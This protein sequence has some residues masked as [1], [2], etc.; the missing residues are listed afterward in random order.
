V[1]RE[2]SPLEPAASRAEDAV[3]KLDGRAAVA[4][5]VPDVTPGVGF[6]A[7]TTSQPR[8]TQR[9][10]VGQALKKGVA[11]LLR[12]TTE[13]AGIGPRQTPGAARAISQVTPA[14]MTL[15][16]DV[17]RAL[18][19]DATTSADGAGQARATAIDVCLRS[20]PTC[21]IAARCAAS[22]RVA[23]VVWALGI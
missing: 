5:K 16:A 11:G 10:V 17:R 22:A 13:S 12:G 9:A 3:G 4:A 14:T 2:R 19:I 18:G 20:V 8:W 6:L 21:V 1:G 15:L 7:A 23:D